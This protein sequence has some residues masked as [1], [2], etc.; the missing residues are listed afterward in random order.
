MSLYLEDKVSAAAPMHTAI[1]TQLQHVKDAPAALKTQAAQLAELQEQNQDFEEQIDELTDLRVKKQTAY[2][3][4]RDNNTRRRL[5][6]IV[7]M[8]KYYRKRIQRKKAVWTEVVNKGLE[9]RAERRKC[10]E[11]V[12]QAKERVGELQA[13]VK[14]RE[15][16]IWDQDNIYDRV[17]GEETGT[18]PDFDDGLRRT[19]EA[20]A[21]LEA[22]ERALEK[23]KQ[24]DKL[25]NKA[26]IETLEV[27]DMLDKA[28]SRSRQIE[29]KGKTKVLEVGDLLQRLRKVENRFEEE[30]YALVLEAGMEPEHA[31]I[32]ELEYLNLGVDRRKQIRM[33][34]GL[35][36]RVT[37]PSDIIRKMYE[38]AQRFESALLR[39]YNSDAA[40]KRVEKCERDLDKAIDHL[41]EVRET[42]F[43]KI[44]TPP[45]FYSEVSREN[46]PPAYT[47][48]C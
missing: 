11:K 35:P 17:F 1:L 4:L 13:A 31:G 18:F 42:A 44:A 30:V 41:R 37:Q 19:R 26:L 23:R 28:L 9:C 2:E 36:K 45:P 33:L 38:D 12:A 29:K 24:A 34:A 25:L 46:K 10:E 14:E 22:A 5:Y 40:E 21:A 32:R 15:R 20:W 3:M 8:E 47:E 6:T 48:I 27:V 7:G 39:E 16:L 43:L